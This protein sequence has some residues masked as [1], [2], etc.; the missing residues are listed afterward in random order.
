MMRGII[1][2]GGVEL[3]EAIRFRRNRAQAVALIIITIVFGIH[4]ALYGAFLKFLSALPAFAAIIAFA[5][6]FSC[7]A[8]AKGKFVLFVP[9]FLAMA[10]LAVQSVIA[11]FYNQ[12]LSVLSVIAAIALAIAVSA[13]YKYYRMLLNYSLFVWVLH[14]LTLAPYL[15]TLYES[16]RHNESMVSDNWVTL[17]GITFQPSEI[18]KF[19]YVFSLSTI[20][21]NQKYSEEKKIAMTIVLSGACALLL[22]MQGEFGSIFIMLAV[23]L[24]IMLT[25]ISR[26]L[27]LLR[28]L[29]VLVA[30]CLILAGLVFLYSQIAD[31]AASA[32]FSNQFAKIEERFEIWRHFDED[33]EDSGYQLYHGLRAMN[34]GGMWG[35]DRLHFVR[36]PV[37]ESDMV[38]PMIVQ[39]YGMAFGLFL[40]LLYLFYAL[41][42][43]KIAT[44]TKDSLNRGIVFGLTTTLFLQACFQIAGSTTVF[45]LSGNTLPFLSRGSTSLLICTLMA[46]VIF[47][48]NQ[49]NQKRASE[50][51]KSNV[52]EE[53]PQPNL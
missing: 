49:F 42:S 20:L 47:R 5:S 41:V 4:C 10:G 8:D 2:D 1:L 3:L 23:Y 15:L 36:V 25:Y 28:V 37:G 21:N 14:F 22:I 35:S 24:I 12:R 6:I 16:Y 26:T 34:A 39:V 29:F 18:A 9:A 50:E 52:I 31:N 11:Y 38:F 53:T 40:V 44:E 7:E 46:A 32:F 45:L 43:L 13:L 27:Y 33:I 30:V 51:K 17:W 19:L 48:I